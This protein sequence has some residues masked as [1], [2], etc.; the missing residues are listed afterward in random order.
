MV[1]EKSKA[2]EAKYHEEIDQLKNQVAQLDSRLEISEHQ[3]RR[4]TLIFEGFN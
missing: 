2:L 4:E 3:E 1:E